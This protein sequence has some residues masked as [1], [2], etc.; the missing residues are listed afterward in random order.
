VSMPLLM[1]QA[2]MSAIPPLFPSLSFAPGA[3]HSASMPPLAVPAATFP[4]PQTHFPLSLALATP[5]PVPPNALALEPPPVPNSIRTQI[6][7]GADVD[8]FSLLSPI[9]PSPADHQIN[10][11]EFSVTLKNSA[12]NPSRI[13]SFAE[14]TI[15]FTRYTEVICAAFPHRRRELSDYRELALSYGGSHFYTY[16]KL[17]AAKRTIRVAQWN[18]CPYWGALDT[19]LH[20]RVFLGCRNISCAVCRSFFHPTISC[21]FINPSIPPCPEPSQ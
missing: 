9:S 11:G 21:P 3:V 19:E 10:C 5:L 20:S 2:P 4:L 14:F 7:T 12:H 8:L 6:L 17:F 15:A 13:L 1:T 16:H 18:Q